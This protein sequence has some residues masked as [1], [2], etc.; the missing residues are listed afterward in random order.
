MHIQV[1]ISAVTPTLPRLVVGSWA[2]QP[3]QG[4]SQPSL[5]VVQETC[6]QGQL[7]NGCSLSSPGV[8]NTLWMVMLQEA[9]PWQMPTGGFQAVHKA[10]CGPKTARSLEP[11]L[12][13]QQL[14]FCLS[15]SLQNGN[16]TSW[17][18]LLSVACE[19][20]L[21]TCCL[22]KQAP[23]VAAETWLFPGTTAEERIYSKL[24]TAFASDFCTGKDP[25]LV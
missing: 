6:L 7:G 4:C 19:G 17:S 20:S 3:C 11:L 1:P 8:P 9:S 24:N 12:V 16:I 10:P 22:A 21:S 18:C 15:S 5:S 2:A 13:T 14:L 25:Q 23:C